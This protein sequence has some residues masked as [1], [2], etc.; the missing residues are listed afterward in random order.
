MQI[1]PS[2]TSALTGNGGAPGG[3]DLNNS[4]YKTPVVS[5]SEKP[6]SH[7]IST[8]AAKTLQLWERGFLRLLEGLVGSLPVFAYLY[9]FQTQLWSH[10]WGGSEAG[11]EGSQPPLSHQ[12]SEGTSPTERQS[13]FSI[14]LCLGPC[15]RLG[16]LKGGLRVRFACRPCLSGGWRAL[17]GLTCERGQRHRA[18][19]TWG[20]DA[21]VT[22]ASA[23]L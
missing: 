11:M 19:E 9:T 17:W 10:R 23:E 8:K 3:D 16:S 22:E 21:V 12:I 1:N 14:A 7:A 15:L 4:N 2:S 18:G 20:C 13:P 5:G 6:C